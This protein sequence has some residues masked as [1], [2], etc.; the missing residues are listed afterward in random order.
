[1]APLTAERVV[2]TR[3]EQER[4]TVSSGRCALG[5][6]RLRDGSGLEK[7]TTG[8]PE[9]GLLPGCATVWIGTGRQGVRELK[10]RHKRRLTA[11]LEPSACI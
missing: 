10:E 1:M 8:R 6:Q 3:D 2:P 5:L 11:E 9:N 7:H 4:Q